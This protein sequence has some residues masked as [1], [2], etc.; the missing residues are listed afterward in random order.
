MKPEIKHVVKSQ[1]ETGVS[2]TPSST[3]LAEAFETFNEIQTGL[4]VTYDDLTYQELKLVS[5]IESVKNELQQKKFEEENNA[6]R[7]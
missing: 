2:P 5:V 7:P 3:V 1:I 4:T 6:G